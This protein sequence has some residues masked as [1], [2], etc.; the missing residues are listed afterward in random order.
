M[1]IWTIVQPWNRQYLTIWYWRCY[2]APTTSLML[3]TKVV[4]QTLLKTVIK[5]FGFILRLKYPMQN[6]NSVSYYPY[7][8]VLSFF[9]NGKYMQMYWKCVAGNGKNLLSTQPWTSA[10]REKVPNLKVQKIKLAPRALILINTVTLIVRY[11]VSC[12]IHV[13]VCEQYNNLLYQL[14]LQ[15]NPDQSRL[16]GNVLPTPPLGCG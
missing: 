11:L 7:I 12:Y 3:R 15:I 1:F 10:Q 6:L 13:H 8:F 9:I 5:L 14:I 16:L 4:G 2:T